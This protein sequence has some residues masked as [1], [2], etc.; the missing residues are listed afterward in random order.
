MYKKRNVIMTFEGHAR[1]LLKKLGID[2]HYNGIEYVIACINYINDGG[3]TFLPNTLKLYE[4]MAK[5]FN[6]AP[7]AIDSNIRQVVRVVFKKRTDLKLIRAIFGDYNLTH[8]PSNMEFLMSILIYIRYYL[9][10]DAYVA[11]EIEEYERKQAK[12]RKPVVPE[13][14]P[15]PTPPVFSIWAKR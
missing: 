7:T 10:F 11:R 2:R 8:R 15:D 9:D 14:E 4:E 5:K 12:K 6:V 1:K 13:P 3:K